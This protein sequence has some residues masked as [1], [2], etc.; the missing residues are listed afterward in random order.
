MVARTSRGRGYSF[1]SAKPRLRVSGLDGVSCMTGD[2]LV[3]LSGA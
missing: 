2:V 3:T 1:K